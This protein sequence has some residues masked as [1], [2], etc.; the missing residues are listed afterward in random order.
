MDHAF[1]TIRT[2]DRACAVDLD[3]AG[4][5]AVVD[6]C[7][8]DTAAGDADAAGGDRAGD[9]DVAGEGLIGNDDGVGDAGKD[10]GAG[11]GYRHDAPPGPEL[12]RTARRPYC[13]LADATRPCCIHF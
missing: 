12:N 8:A 4:D 5:G 1:Q 3:A 13:W 10:R 9:T 11:D 6:D 7:A 2:C